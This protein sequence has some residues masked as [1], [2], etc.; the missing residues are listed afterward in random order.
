MQF[1][2]IFWAGFCHIPG[3]PK[4]TN[5]TKLPVTKA[6]HPTLDRNW[7]IDFWNLDVKWVFIAMPFGFLVTLLFYYDVKSTSIRS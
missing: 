4:D 2:T 7:V 1:G 5:T 3:A 6:F